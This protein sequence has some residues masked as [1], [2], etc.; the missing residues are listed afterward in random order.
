MCAKV[1]DKP[2]GEAKQTKSQIVSEITPMGYMMRVYVARFMTSLIQYLVPMTY[3][4]TKGSICWAA[5][6][7]AALLSLPCQTLIN[8]SFMKP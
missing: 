6:R 3:A 1:P 8:I 5:A 4:N 7:Y 2:R